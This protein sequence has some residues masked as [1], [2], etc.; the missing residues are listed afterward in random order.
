M[1]RRN[2]GTTSAQRPVKNPRY[3]LAQK[4]GS[5]YVKATKTGGTT[6]QPMYTRQQVIDM[7]YAGELWDHATALF[8][9][10]KVQIHD[11]S[12]PVDIITV[13]VDYS[14]SSNANDCGVCDMM[15]ATFK[16]LGGQYLTPA[17]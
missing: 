14:D 16:A 7:G 8:A 9:I 6:I 1:R 17:Q 5:T 12:I 4:N 11:D 3:Y 10:N 2:Q 15:N 13:K